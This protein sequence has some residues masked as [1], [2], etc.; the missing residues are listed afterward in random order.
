MKAGERLWLSGWTRIEP[1][2]GPEVDIVE[3]RAR[4]QGTPRPMTKPRV[5]GTFGRCSLPGGPAA[6]ALRSDRHPLSS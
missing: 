1:T 4:R 2:S 6:A 3:R 5:R